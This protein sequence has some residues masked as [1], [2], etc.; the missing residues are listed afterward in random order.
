MST[1]SIILNSLRGLEESNPELFINTVLYTQSTNYNSIE[2]KNDIIT[3]ESDVKLII[4]VLTQ[5]EIDGTLITYHT[6]KAIITKFSV[7]PKETDAIL[8]GGIKYE[9]SRIQ[10][11]YVGNIVVAYVVYLNA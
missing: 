3:T 11:I 9:I 8:I 5:T 2:L 6:V 1:V 4:D 7:E 10:P